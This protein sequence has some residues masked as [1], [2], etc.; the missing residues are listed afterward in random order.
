MV[1]HE[2]DERNDKSENRKDQGDHE[3]DGTV[4]FRGFSDPII[5]AD[6]AAPNGDRE[7]PALVARIC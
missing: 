2:R 4:R 7:K 1:D 6:A 5:E 3:N